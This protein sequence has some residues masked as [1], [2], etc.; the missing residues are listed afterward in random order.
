MTGDNPDVLL[1][2]VVNLLPTEPT[3][4]SYAQERYLARERHLA[5]APGGVLLGE[6]N[7]MRWTE[8]VA[9]EPAM[10][11][12][13]FIDA[14]GV[15]ETPATGHQVGGDHYSKMGIH[16]PWQVLPN[17]MTPEELRGFAKGTAVVYLARE[18]DKGGDQD[19]EKAIHTLQLYLETR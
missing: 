12:E 16:Q 18:G 10:T 5:Q 6:D 3:P 1:E 15:K 2:E 8:E 9:P 4:P 14:M 7:P 11:K 17:W 13:E 19:I